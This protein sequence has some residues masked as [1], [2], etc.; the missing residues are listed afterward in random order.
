MYCILLYKGFKP[1]FEHR[2]LNGGDE[3][4]TFLIF[5]LFFFGFLFLMQIAT[6]YVMTLEDISKL[7]GVFECMRWER[8]NKVF[9]ALLYVLIVRNVLHAPFSLDFELLSNNL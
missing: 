6:S 8:P 1:P 5:F 9:P 3:F 2:K 7:R 4:L